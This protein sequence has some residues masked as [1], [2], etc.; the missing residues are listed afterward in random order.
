MRRVHL[1]GRNNILKRLLVHGV[2]FN[3]SLIRRQTLGAGK[4]RRLQGLCLEFFAL[5]ARLFLRLWTKPSLEE[6]ASEDFALQSS[7]CG[8][9][10]PLW[11]DA[12]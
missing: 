5:I 12:I 7:L 10:D 3:L 9:G 6:R 4:P 2:A 11:F 1:R 8:V